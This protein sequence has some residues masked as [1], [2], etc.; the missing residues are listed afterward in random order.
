MSMVFSGRYYRR[1]NLDEI[2][3]RVF[4]TFAYLFFHSTRHVVI[5]SSFHEND[6]AIAILGLYCQTVS[7]MLLVKT[8]LVPS[9][10]DIFL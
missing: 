10:L 1:I 3:E 4:R 6:K 2:S 9:L 5:H 8:N 7:S